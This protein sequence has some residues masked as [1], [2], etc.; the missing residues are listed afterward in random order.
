PGPG[1]RLH[2]ARQ[3]RAARQRHRQGGARRHAGQ[4]GQL[5]PAVTDARPGW[6]WTPEP[7][8]KAALA[9]HG[10]T[11]PRGALVSSREEARAVAATLRPPLVVKVV[12]PGVVHKS[13]VG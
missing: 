4:A 8:V 10:A 9:R 11:V 6:A 7:D 12:A 1:P 3:P 2:P 5:A 13:D